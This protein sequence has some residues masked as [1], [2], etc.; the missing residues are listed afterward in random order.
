MNL[1]RF[2]FLNL[3]LI[4]GAFIASL[5]FNG[6]D[7]RLY[8]IAFILL[9][10]WLFSSSLR[11]YSHG[12]QL[13]N[14]LLPACVI[15]FWLWLGLNILFSPV[16]YLSVVNFWWVGIF[17]LTFL[18]FTFTPDKD[19][20]WRWLFASLVVVVAILCLYA[21]YQMYVLH[22]PPRATFFNKNSLAALLNLLLLPIFA[23]ALKADKKHTLYASL[24]AVFLFSLLLTLINSRGALLGFGVG[25]AILLLMLL[26]Q[27][28]KNRLLI[29][30]L[31]LVLAFVTAELLFDYAPHTTGTGMVE[32]FLTLQDTQSAGH[33]RFVIWQPAWELFL[34]H[35]WFG[36]GL[37]T[38]F[39]T[40]PPALH[41]DDVSAGFYVHNDYL[42]LALETGLPG[43]L[44]L[45][46]LLLAT[47]YRLLA[48]LAISRPADPRRLEL[49]AL[50]AAL[51]TLAMHSFFTY[52]LYVMPVM[53]IAGLLLGR[54]NQLADR[55]NDQPL[56]IRRPANLF[57]SSLYYP[58]VGIIT[59][60]L[61][62]FFI[63]GGTAY[64]YQ[65][66]G[67]QLAAR[68]QLESAH[69]AFRLAQ[70]LAPRVD[71]AYYADADLLRKSARALTNRP[72]LAQG[73]LTEAQALLV[74]AEALNPLRAQTPYI[75]GLLQEQLAPEHE[76]LIIQAYQQALTRNPRFLPARLALARYLK[77]H[78][79]EQEAFQVLLQGLEYR[80]RQL[81]PAYLEL[82]QMGSAQAAQMHQPE[83]AEQLAEL[84]TDYRQDYAAMRSGLRDNHILNPY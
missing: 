27:L 56:L 47:F 62:S 5:F 59:I 66:Q 40:I 67:Y 51:L 16:A 13:G 19:Q 53:L 64:H 34:Q 18:L 61:A 2:N 25:L 54:F 3:I 17:P 58:L 36:I 30:G 81:S 9:L 41:I 21:L 50:F 11:A 39:L 1:Q 4:I 84:L 52:N 49:V 42:Q 10:G 24:A 73:L 37:G 63:R 65:Q 76:T 28:D 6:I 55:L 43:L 71:S 68:N 23:F 72:E 32:R 78:G 20:L 33:S 77:A 60:T 35:R 46:V 26:R 31:I 83:L 14:L 82:L 48:S 69:R 8:A 57:R 22:E 7:I 80:Y 45:I 29:T 70:R 38:Y 15:L 74:R 44:L 79:Q 75:R 12:Y